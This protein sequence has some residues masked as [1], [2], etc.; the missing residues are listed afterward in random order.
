MSLFKNFQLQVAIFFT[1]IDYLPLL[2]N[3]KAILPVAVQLHGDV[4]GGNPAFLLDSEPG[5]DHSGYGKSTAEPNGPAIYLAVD[6]SLECVDMGAE[7]RLYTH[8]HTKYL[9]NDS[10]LV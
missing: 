5:H 7:K 1:L 3:L 10:I 9:S 4:V 6:T 2:A 8:T